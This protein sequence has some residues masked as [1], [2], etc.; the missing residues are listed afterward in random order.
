MFADTPRARGSNDTDRH[1]SANISMSSAHSARGS[2]MDYDR[3]RMVEPLRRPLPMPTSHVLAPGEGL[4]TPVFTRGF[5]DAVI[6]LLFVF[7][8]QLSFVCLSVPRPTV[9]FTHMGPDFQKILGR[10]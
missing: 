3:P 8:S 10:T 1:S 7:L 6:R 5:S 4:L 9:R 2:S